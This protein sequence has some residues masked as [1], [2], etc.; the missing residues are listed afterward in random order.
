MLSIS[1]ASVAAD[2]R[3]DSRFPREDFSESSHTSE[4]KIGT[5]V[6]TL[7]GAWR[8][9]VSSGTGWSG[10]SML[11]LGEIESLICNIYISVVARTIV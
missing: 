7:L 2:P 5:P 10:V 4:S 8:Y 6:A 11:R 3:F 9:R 1:A